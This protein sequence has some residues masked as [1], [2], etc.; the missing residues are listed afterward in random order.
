MNRRER[1]IMEKQL[2]LDKYKKTMPRFER[3]EMIRQN[4]IEGRKK[5]DQLKEERRIKDNAKE[6]ELLNKKIS[7]RA[8]E[9]M[10]KDSMDYYSA[11]EKAKKEY[12]KKA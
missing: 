3:F 11:N 8:L 6:E 10:M 5:E 12:S 4:I 1:K 7:D 2:G 9:L